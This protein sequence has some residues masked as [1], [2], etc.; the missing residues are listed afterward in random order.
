[1]RHVNIMILKE[2]QRF[3]WKVY[4]DALRAGHFTDALDVAAKTL[5]EQAAEYELFLSDPLGRGVHVS[6]ADRDCMYLAAI[7]GRLD[8]IDR[9]ITFEKLA[10]DEAR[11]PYRPFGFDVES[12]RGIETDDQMRVRHDSASRAATEIHTERLQQA[13]EHKT[14]HARFTAILKAVRRSPG[15]LQV[16]LTSAV[17][18]RDTK[19]ITRMVD[20]LE[21]AGLVVTGKVGN[22]VAVWSADSPDVPPESKRR[23]QRW[24]WAFEDFL[25]DQPLEWNDPARTVAGLERLAATVNAAA[26]EPASDEGLRPTPLDF[27]AHSIHAAPAIS[28]GIPVYYDSEELAMAFWGHQDL[29]ATAAWAQR[30]IDGGGYDTTANQKKKWLRAIP[31][32]THVER[33]PFIERL[34]HGYPGWLLKEVGEPTTNSVPVTAFTASTACSDPAEALARQTSCWIKQK[35]ART[36]AAQSPTS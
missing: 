11:R 15:M 36:R 29:D 4:N 20:Q 13:Q 24:A 21:A 16:D 28:E 14:D 30:I 7:F 33:V 18:D 6:A 22:R 23:V 34:L 12:H 25:E 27:V 31:R 10:L 8:I 2:L 17:P 1:M 5:D 26:A 32:H 35:P 9:Y 3:R 19:A